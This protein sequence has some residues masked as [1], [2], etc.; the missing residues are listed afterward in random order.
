MK[1]ILLASSSPR[2]TQLLTQIGL[3]HKVVVPAFDERGR[4]AD[5]PEHLVV[6]LA[7]AKALSV[8]EIQRE[9]M[10][11]G[12]DTIVVLQGEIFGK[13]DSPEHALA[14]LTRLQGQ[15]HQVY[16]GV[17]VVD[18]GTGIVKT[19]FRRVD[20]AM[21]PC[22]ESELMGYIRTGEPLDKAGAYSIQGRGS[23]LVEEI[24]GD[25]Y[26]VVGLPLTLTVQLLTQFDGFSFDIFF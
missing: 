15:V 10:I 26:A 8:A 13:P 9:G 19:G 1:P 12:A 22:E 23:L 20:V 24:R 6:D 4:T 14:M 3:E 25:Y 21:K 17:A 11:I 5:T 16:S 7:T 2:R 18:A